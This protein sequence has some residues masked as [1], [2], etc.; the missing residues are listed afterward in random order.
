MLE[1][2]KVSYDFNEFIGNDK[3]LMKKINLRTSK[4]QNFWEFEAV[5]THTTR[6]YQHLKITD[7]HDL[8]TKPMIEFIHLHLPILTS[9][10]ITKTDFEDFNDFLLV[11]HNIEKNIEKIHLEQIYIKVLKR[12][13][14]QLK[15]QMTFP[16]LKVLETICCQASIYHEV[17]IECKNLEKFII[18]SGDQ[19]STFAQQA[20]M[21]ILKESTKLKVLGIHFNIFNLIFNEDIA[22]SWKFKLREFYA[23][24]LHR[25]LSNQFSI[26]INF[27]HFLLLQM[28]TLETISISN[29][30]GMHVLDTIFHVPQLKNLTIKGFHNSES[31]IEWNKIELHANDCIEMM[32]MSDMSKNFQMFRCIISSVKNLKEISLYS[33]DDESL[34]FIVAMCSKIQCIYAENSE[35]SSTNLNCGL[36]KVLSEYQKIKRYF[37]K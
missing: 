35:V 36:V 25:I 17:F 13:I 23:N 6:S 7:F 15:S 16:K 8:I 19:I 33:I 11:A 10:T 21:N 29:W 4:V 31:T 37:M 24:D 12:K 26:Q 30:F 2:S 27:Q 20:V 34:N 1:L 18:K 14:C 9:I 3:K 5:L 32:N 28:D 22:A